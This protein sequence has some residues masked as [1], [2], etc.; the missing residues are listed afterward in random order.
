MNIQKFQKN[1]RRQIKRYL[2]IIENSYGTKKYFFINKIFITLV[3]NQNIINRSRVLYF[4]WLN[5]MWITYYKSIDIIKFLIL[6]KENSD[7]TNRVKYPPNLLM[8]L[9]KYKR[10]MEKMMIEEYL[11]LPSR[12]PLDLKHYVISFLIPDKQKI[13]SFYINKD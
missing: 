7:Q 9:K 13:V 8:N 12:L 5:F 2:D 4:E 1:F 6:S 11:K 10:R 3:K